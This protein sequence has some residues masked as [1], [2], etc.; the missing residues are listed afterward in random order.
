[1]KGTVIVA[2]DLKQRLRQL[3]RQ[4]EESGDVCP[5]CHFRLDAVR[6][7]IISHPSRHDATRPPLPPRA[8]SDVCGTCGGGMTIRITEEWPREEPTALF[9]DLNLPS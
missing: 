3:E 1:L 2:G 5:E 4:R 9:D 7:I 6:E 8:A